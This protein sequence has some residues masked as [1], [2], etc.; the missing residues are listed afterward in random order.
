MLKNIQKG[1]VISNIFLI[2][3]N[4]GELKNGNFF[5]RIY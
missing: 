1:E 5:N 4:N 2:L 3:D